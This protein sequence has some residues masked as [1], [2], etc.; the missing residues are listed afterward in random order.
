[1]RT[2]G[3]DVEGHLMFW[4]VYLRVGLSVVGKTTENIRELYRY[5]VMNIS[6]G[7][8]NEIFL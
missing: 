2:I 8:Q 1:M 5:E 7:R 3:T 6:N 4:K